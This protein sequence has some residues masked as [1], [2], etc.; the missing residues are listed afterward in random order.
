MP[1]SVGPSHP[2]MARPQAADGATASHMEGSC[3]YIESAVVQP[4][5]GG[6]PV[7]ILDEVL[8]T[9]HGTSLRCNETFH[10]ASVGRLLRSGT[11]FRVTKSA[12]NFSLNWGPVSVSGRAPHVPVSDKAIIGINMFKVQKTI[13]PLPAK[14][15]NMVSS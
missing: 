5:R 7:L 8:T 9:L 15:E 1:Q 12:G 13:N 2:G 10:I 11:N 3:D 4:T 6:A 14:V